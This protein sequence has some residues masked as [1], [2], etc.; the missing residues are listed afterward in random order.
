MKNFEHN[1]RRNR[2]C[3]ADTQIVDLLKLIIQKGCDEPMCVNLLKGI[4][5]YVESRVHVRMP[6]KMINV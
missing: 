5:L 1:L 2:D 3:E 4:Q 6:E